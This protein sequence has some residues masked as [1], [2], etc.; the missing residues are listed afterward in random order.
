MQAI[1]GRLT[2][3][4]NFRYLEILSLVERCVYLL[5]SELGPLNKVLML[6]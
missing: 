2:Y 3:S 6:F 5:M 4:S 1:D